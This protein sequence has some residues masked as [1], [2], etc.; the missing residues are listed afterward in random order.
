[1]YLITNDFFGGSLIFVLIVQI[2]KFEP[3]AY[4]IV[5]FGDALLSNYECAFH[6]YLL[7]FF[8]DHGDYL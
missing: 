3:I 5:A 4:F 6:E 2:E 7:Y 8:G 1:M